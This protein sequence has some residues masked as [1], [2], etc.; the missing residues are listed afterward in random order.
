MASKKTHY[1]VL[2]GRLYV[3]LNC[4]TLTSVP[5]PT[6]AEKR[7]INANSGGDPCVFS[8]RSKCN[9]WIRISHALH[10]ILRVSHS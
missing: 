7:N 9:G 6:S 1:G 4:N 8:T 3:R 2:C 10:F 5:G